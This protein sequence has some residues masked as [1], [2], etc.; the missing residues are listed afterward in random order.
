[1]TGVFLN[2][3]GICLYLMFIRHVSLFITETEAKLIW[4]DE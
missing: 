4:N 2:M 3:V 1:M